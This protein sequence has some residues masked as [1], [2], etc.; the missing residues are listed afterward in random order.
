MTQPAEPM[1][2]VQSA[3]AYQNRNAAMN[4][5]IHGSAGLN[6]DQQAMNAGGPPRVHSPGPAWE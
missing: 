4:E 3:P 5:G 1:G 2:G 6:A